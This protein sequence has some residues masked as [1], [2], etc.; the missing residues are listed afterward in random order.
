MGAAD[1]QSGA[2]LLDTLSVSGSGSGWAHETRSAA[3]ARLRDMGLPI[4]GHALT[5]W[6]DLGGYELES[7]WAAAAARSVKTPVDDVAVRKDGELSG[8]ERKRSGRVV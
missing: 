8:G 2:G 5:T 7:Q 1:I 4:F 3:L 6:G